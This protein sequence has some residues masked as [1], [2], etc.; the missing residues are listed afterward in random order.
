M[1]ILHVRI[2]SY[3]FFL[4]CTEQFKT[5]LK[6]N[7]L[8]NVFSVTNSIFTGQHTYSIFSLILFQKSTSLS[9]IRTKRIYPLNNMLLGIFDTTLKFSINSYSHFPAQVNIIEMSKFEFIIWWWWN[10]VIFIMIVIIHYKQI[11]RHPAKSFKR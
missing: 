6:V 11:F 2:F 7:L 1:K 3:T 4:K 5:S 9:T 10:Q 8:V